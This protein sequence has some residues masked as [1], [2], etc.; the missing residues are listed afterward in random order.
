[1]LRYGFFL[2]MLFFLPA[3]CALGPD[4]IRPELELPTATNI[5]S[6]QFAPFTAADWWKI[7]ND[8]TLDRIQTEAL[9]Y[10]HDLKAAAARVEQARAFAREAFADRL[11]SIGTSAA[12]GRERASQRQA[13]PAGSRT[14][15]F[16]ETFGYASF[17]IDFWGQYRRLDEAA[18]AELLA[19]EAGRDA[20][21]LSLTANVAALYFNLRTLEAQTRI[22]R[23]QLATHDITYDMYLKRY[24]AGYTQ[25]LDLR[26]IEADRL[27]TAALVYRRENALSQAQTAL[28]VL[29]GRSPARIVQGFSEEGRALEQLNVFPRI[30]EDIPSDLLTLRPDIR[31]EEGMLMAANARIGAARAAFFPSIRLT[32]GSGFAS[33]ELN[34]LFNRDAYVWNAAA[35]LTQP[36]FEGGRLFARE[37]AARARHEQM[38]ARYEQTVQNAFRETRDAL[39]AGTKTAQALEA[40]LERARSMRRSFELSKIQQDSGHISIIDVLDIQRQSLRA[41]L[42]LTEAQR[43]QLGA[44]IALCRAMG[45]GW[46]ESLYFARVY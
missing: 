46:H 31:R 43:D 21:R 6:A 19:T 5:D 26:R 18:R 24:L 30:P 17:E 38:L 36:V 35:A 2:L 45:G 10:N 16:F 25:E 11:P 20:V 44:V 33:S 15:D 23:E 3:G 9:A 29:L 8:P 42:D 41:E 34:N 40:S 12:A 37:K 4:Y 39:V 13:P 1:M 27:A 22:A 28:A 32:G 14:A 7:F